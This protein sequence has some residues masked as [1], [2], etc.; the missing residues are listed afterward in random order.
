[1]R[2]AATCEPYR[3]PSTPAPRP[4]GMLQR[5]PAWM[6]CVTVTQARQSQEQP[7]PPLLAGISLVLLNPL[8]LPLF[9]SLCQGL[10]FFCGISSSSDNKQSPAV[11]L[12]CESAGDGFDNVGH[13]GCE[14]GI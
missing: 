14:S 10:G 11:T 9:H 1:M 8:S 4:T 6:G 7:P 5:I 3:Q 2:G 12:W 13:K